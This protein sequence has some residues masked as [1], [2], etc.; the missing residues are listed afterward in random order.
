MGGTGKIKIEENPESNNPQVK[1]KYIPNL[2]EGICTFSE[3]G[4]DCKTNKSIRK[5]KTVLFNY[6]VVILYK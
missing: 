6:F 5:S 1:V 4:I 3:W 2:L